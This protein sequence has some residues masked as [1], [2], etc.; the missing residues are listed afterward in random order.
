ME[1][2]HSLVEA[3]RRKDVEAFTVLVR[4][5]QAM[6]FGSAYANVRDF[7]A[8]EEIAQDAFL[9]AWC[10]LEKLEEPDKFGGWLRGIVRFGCAHWWRKSRLA[11]TSLEDAGN[12]RELDPDPAELAESRETRDAVLQAISALPVALREVTILYYLQEHSQK[13]M[14]AF[15]GLPVSTVK[16]RLRSARQALK[17]GGLLEM[18]SP[19]F[20]HHQ[21]DGTFADR[22]GRIVRQDGAM[23]DV[24]FSPEHRP[25]VLNAVEMPGA[26]SGAT[27]GSVVQHLGDDLARVMVMRE[28]PGQ[29]TSGPQVR[30]TGEAV[31]Q[32]I[33]ASIIGKVIDSL[34]AADVG[35]QPVET[36]IKVIDLFCPIVPGGVIGLTGDSQSG[37]MVL[38]EELIYRLADR[39]MEPVTVL[40]FVELSA[41]VELIQATPYR[42][43]GN[44]KAMYIPADRME[45]GMTDW[46]TSR[47]DAIIVFSQELARS[48]IYPAIDPVA[49]G[50]RMEVPAVVD[51]ARDILRQNPEGHGDERIGQIRAFLKQWFYVAEE[52]THHPGDSVPVEQA[53]EE[54]ERIISG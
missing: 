39:E 25:P 16:N 13:Q 36:G 9:T 34:G 11:T 15:L 41:E 52:F 26:E 12:V 2:I 5:Y 4:K 33:S 32:A 38:V 6:A 50:S 46:L 18:T 22:I 10:N 49:S 8:A 51:R 44:V 20:S 43:S 14:G 47:L 17:Q 48:R 30:D 42:T 28:S 40:V 31:S 27:F 53:A 45:P 1:E 7:S 3:A 19:E 23:L 29:F 37:K 35:T 54:L 24:R 21:L